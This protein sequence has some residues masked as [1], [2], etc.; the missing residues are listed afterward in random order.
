MGLDAPE[1]VIPQGLLPCAILVHYL[2]NLL[3]VEIEQTMFFKRKFISYIAL[4]FGD[5]LSE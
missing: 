4:S 3:L 1:R 2:G 5:A